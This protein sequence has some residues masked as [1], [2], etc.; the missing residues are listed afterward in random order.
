MYNEAKM[1]KMRYNGGFWGVTKEQD[2]SNC[3]ECGKCV[4]ACPQ[5]INIPDWLKKVHA[6]LK[7]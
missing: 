1:A 6:E 7:N 5:H 3:I 2:A 4:E